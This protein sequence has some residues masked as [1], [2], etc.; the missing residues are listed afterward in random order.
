MK[1]IECSSENSVCAAACPRSVRRQNDRETA[2]GKPPPRSK[3]HARFLVGQ[4]SSDKWNRMQPRR[5]LYS[6]DAEARKG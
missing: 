4:R 5:I 3:G 1:A 2:V 6:S